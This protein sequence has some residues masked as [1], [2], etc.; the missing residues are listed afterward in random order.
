MYAQWN[1]YVHY[2]SSVDMHDK[3]YKE[4][5]DLSTPSLILL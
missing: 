2:I 1:V 4:S 5:T 3:Q